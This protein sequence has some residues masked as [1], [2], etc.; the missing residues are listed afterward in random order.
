M[1]NYVGEKRVEY[2]HRG[3]AM[4][5]IGVLQRNDVA[6]SS[7]I[8]GF[9]EEWR[10]RNKEREHIEDEPTQFLMLIYLYNLYSVLAQ[11]W[12]DRQFYHSENEEENTIK[13]VFNLLVRAEK[14]LYNICCQISKCRTESSRG[15][16]LVHIRG[17]EDRSG[18]EH[19][20]YFLL[21]RPNY[22]SI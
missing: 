9:R 13:I 7:R 17:F 14:E 12:A 19:H 11:Q 10:A 2:I 16:Y 1:R 21:Y 15:N 18:G 6:L 3:L 20:F 5:I 8:P 4:R 22:G